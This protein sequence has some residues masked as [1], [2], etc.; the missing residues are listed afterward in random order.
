[1]PDI[2]AAEIAANPDILNGVVPAN[3]LDVIVSLRAALDAA[4]RDLEIER[5]VH[6]AC[7]ERA[8]KNHDAAL[9]FQDRALL[10]ERRLATSEECR[11]NL[12]NSNG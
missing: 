8:N 1:M 7:R 11:T 6:S 9:G 4:K 2:T 3:A 12:H 5:G 10:A